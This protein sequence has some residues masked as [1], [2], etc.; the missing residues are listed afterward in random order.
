MASGR[1]GLFTSELE[2]A[3]NFRFTFDKPGPKPPVQYVEDRLK[4]KNENGEIK[5]IVIIQK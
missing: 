4:I 5:K 3:S 2:A 1:A